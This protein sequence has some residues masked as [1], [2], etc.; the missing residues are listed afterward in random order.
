MISGKK[1]ATAALC[2]GALLSACGGATAGTRELKVSHFE[3]GG[4]Q[5]VGSGR[6]VTENRAIGNFERL[7]IDG[8]IDVVIRQG[9]ARS[10]Q[11]NAEDNIMELVRADAKGGK[12]SLGTKGS[13]RTRKGISV[14][15]TIPTLDAVS[16][17]ASG[18]VRFDGWDAD[19]IELVIGGSGDIELGGSV[20]NVRALISGSGD[21][22]LAPVRLSYVDAEIDGSGEIRM[23]SLRKLDA[24]INGSGSIEAGIVG[25]LD[26]ILNGSGE[27]LYRS[28][29]RILRQERNGSGRIARH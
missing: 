13:F 2:A 18:N 20:D 22:D 1:I 12:L 7:S 23:G 25:E 21:I 8:P 24:R 17:N 10:L 28:A 6:M 29:D 15:L 9:S 27:I 3:N 5:V 14:V 11:L 4:M 26:A 19:A 16:I